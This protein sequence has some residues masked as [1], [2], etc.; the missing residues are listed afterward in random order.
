VFVSLGHLGSLLGRQ[1]V[2]DLR[3]HF[4][5]SD[6]HF[7]L[8]LRSRLSRRTNG[9]LIKG[10]ARRISLT[11]MKRAHLI[12]QRLGL[13]GEAFMNLFDL[14]LLGVTQVQPSQRSKVASSSRAMRAVTKQASL[15]SRRTVR[16]LRRVLRKNDSRGRQQ[17]RTCDSRSDAEFFPIQF[18]VNTPF[19]NS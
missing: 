18:H 1:D 12:A 2:R 8:N 13:F 6:F 9:C 16:A 7:H 3:H 17:E 14:F 15:R 4:R 11:F 10:A 19:E 5:V